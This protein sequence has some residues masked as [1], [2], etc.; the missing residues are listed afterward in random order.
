MDKKMIAVMLLIVFLLIGL[1]GCYTRDEPGKDTDGDSYPDSDDEFPNNPDEWIDS[2]NDGIGNNEDDFPNDETLYESYSVYDSLTI[3]KNN[4]PW[5]ISSDES[6][7]F[8]WSIT[9]DW[10]YVYVNTST[11]EN[12]NGEWVIQPVC[13][14]ITLTNPANTYTINIGNPLSRIPV[15]NENSGEWEFRVVNSCDNQLQVSF[16]LSMYK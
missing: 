8:T 16:V 9:N 7:E 15:T 5:L 11:R 3:E 2:D 13:P 14:K 6:K 10:K 12:V 4:D 1:T